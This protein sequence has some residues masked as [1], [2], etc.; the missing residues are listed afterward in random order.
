MDKSRLQRLLSFIFIGVKKMKSFVSTLVGGALGLVALYV[1]GKVSFQ[2]GYD[3]CD[4]EHRRDELK[5]E[6][7]EACVN[8]PELENEVESE[9]PKKN[10]FGILKGVKKASVISKLIKHPDDHQIEAYV[11]GEDVQVRIKPRSM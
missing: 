2:I 11:D 7:H 1:V 4:L 6:V 10:R 8:K 9:V 5:K 3:I